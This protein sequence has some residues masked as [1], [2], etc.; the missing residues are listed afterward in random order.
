MYIIGL[1]ENR[2][3]LLARESVISYQ[4]LLFTLWKNSKDFKDYGIKE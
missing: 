3:R 4:R 1:S 2:Y